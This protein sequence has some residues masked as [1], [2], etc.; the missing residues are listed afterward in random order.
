M[1]R[2]EM[3]SKT[4]IQNNPENNLSVEIPKLLYNTSFLLDAVSLI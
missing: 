4:S 1:E 3:V 2:K